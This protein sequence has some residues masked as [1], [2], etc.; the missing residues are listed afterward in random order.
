MALPGPGTFGGLSAETPCYTYNW[1]NN[2]GA[3]AQ[4]IV[5]TDC[6]GKAGITQSPGSSIGTNGTF[7]ARSANEPG[8]VSVN[9]AGSC[10]CKSWYNRIFNAQKNANYT[11]SWIDC[12]GQPA[13][14]RITTSDGVGPGEASFYSCSKSKPILI[15]S[16]GSHD[17][18]QRLEYQY[19]NRD[20]VG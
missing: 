15:I 12:N 3:G 16:G 10:P 4:T 18:E 2:V 17:L 7:C 19:C 6:N 11:F 13:Q 8:G 5:Y 20:L 9:Q 1:N 14:K